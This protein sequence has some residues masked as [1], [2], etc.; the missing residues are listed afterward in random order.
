MFVLGLLEGV[1]AAEIA[2]LLGVP[3]NTIY[4]RMFALRKELDARLA[5]REVET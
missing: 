4:S 2:A 3:L 5:E 1:P